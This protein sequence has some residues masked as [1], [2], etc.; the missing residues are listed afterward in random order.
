MKFSSLKEAY[1]WH[2]TC[3]ICKEPC[4]H[5]EPNKNVISMS[6]LTKG[7]AR[8]KS[9]LSISNIDTDYI[10]AFRPKEYV[11]YKVRAKLSFDDN[12]YTAS[13]P[14][15]D[16]T[17]SCRCQRGCFLKFYE[18]LF[19][20]SFYWIACK[21]ELIYTK[22]IEVYIQ[23]FREQNTQIITPTGE[24]IELHLPIDSDIGS[25]LKIIDKYIS[26]M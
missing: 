7:I 13:T 2:D 19:A 6:A 12:S 26:F 21:S 22:N 20:K 25:T 4:V 17:L 8:D 9:K 15:A 24:H 11:N 5:T 10:S 1:A 3:P 23:N 14:V 18:L 16:G